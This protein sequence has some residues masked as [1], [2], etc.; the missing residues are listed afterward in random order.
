MSALYVDTDM[1]TDM[2]AWSPSFTDSLNAQVFLFSHTEMVTLMD[3]SIGS[4]IETLKS[5]GMY[6]N[7]LVVFMS[8]VSMS[9]KSLVP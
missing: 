8:D 9:P 7:S 1:D 3:S 6:E 4:I 2:E 5:R